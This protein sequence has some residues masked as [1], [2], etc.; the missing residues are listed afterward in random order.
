MIWRWV[1]ASC[2]VMAI[3]FAG[4]SDG[5]AEPQVTQNI[6]YYD[7]SGATASEVRANLNRLGPLDPSGRR[8]DGFTRWSVK[9]TFEY[10]DDAVGCAI[11][12]ASTTVE[13]SITMPRLKADASV[14][15]TLMRAFT[16][17]SDKLLQHEKWHVQNAI[18]V[19]RRIENI[20]RATA[21]ERT[22]NLLGRF[23]N[24][25]GDRL[26]KE[27]VEKDR[28]YDARTDHGRNEGARFP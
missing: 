26:L 10:K 18:D 20:I 3:A 11:A 13:A 12:S 2:C 15:A 1:A 4:M 27:A 22:C 24:S 6:V 7:V 14:P 8:N 28:D 25:L 19:A 16:D 5:L 9:W 23:A 21:P 17:Y